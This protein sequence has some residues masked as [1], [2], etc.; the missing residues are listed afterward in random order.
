MQASRWEQIKQE[1]MTDV[2][3]IINLKECWLRHSLIEEIGLDRLYRELELEPLIFGDLKFDYYSPAYTTFSSIPD[4]DLFYYRHTQQLIDNVIDAYIFGKQELDFSERQISKLPNNLAKLCK[5]TYLNVSHN[6]LE[7]LTPPLTNLTNLTNIDISWNHVTAL[8]DRLDRMSNLKI[9]TLH[10]NQIV[11]LSPLQCFPPERGLQVNFI[12]DDLPRKYWTKLC[13]WQT[14]WL[15][16]E[17]EDRIK[18]TI[19]NQVGFDRVYQELNLKPLNLDVLKIETNY[20]DYEDDFD[21]IS[22]DEPEDECNTNPFDDADEALLIESEKIKIQAD[23]V[24]VYYDCYPI[25]IYEDEIR[26]SEKSLFY[27]TKIV[28]A[29]ASRGNKLSLTNGNISTLPDDIGSLEQ[30]ASLDLRGNFLSDIPNSFGELSNLEELSISK[31]KFQYLPEIVTRLTKLNLL[32]IS[33]NQISK[34]PQTISILSKLEFID[35]SDN[36]IDDLSALQSCSDKLEVRLF[37]VSLPRRY[38]TRFTEWE[39]QWLLDE[40]NAE[41]RRM[42][43]Q[44]V[45]YERICQELKAK[46]IDNWREYTI[47]KIDELQRIYNWKGEEL[48]REPMVLLK[49]TCPS[50]GH[51]HILRVPPNTISA[52]AAITWVNH[53]I[54]PDDIAIQT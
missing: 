52:E 48:H 30:L 12:K 47:L 46:E 21:P 3:L 4:Y 9:L 32:D 22:I 17:D 20:Q 24:D 36:P 43:I 41:I 34:L 18:E 44:Q 7:A 53:G 15:L 45:G 1:V 26:K 38:W 37:N 54:H 11:D 23:I 28:S 39:A 2:K 6:S 16:D 5:L 13:D 8:P 14:I 25:E 33:S 40:D 31:N 27:K 19:I 51:I 49:M 42:L 50:T 29:Y 10:G 35:L